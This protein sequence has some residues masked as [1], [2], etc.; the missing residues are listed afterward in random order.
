MGQGQENKEGRDTRGGWRGRQGKTSQGHIRILDL[1]LGA[2]G[3]GVMPSDSCLTKNVQHLC[4]EWIG[5]K[6][7]AGREVWSLI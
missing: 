7:T 3:R 2:V 4:R 6:R 5:D 1:S